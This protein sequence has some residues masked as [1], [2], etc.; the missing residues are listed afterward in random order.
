[1]NFSASLF[2][3]Y[4]GGT[5]LNSNEQGVVNV[6]VNAAAAVVHPGYNSAN[7]NNDIALI[8]LPFALELTGRLYKKT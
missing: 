2:T 5:R 8:R 4:L 6:E 7:L 3:L 1:M